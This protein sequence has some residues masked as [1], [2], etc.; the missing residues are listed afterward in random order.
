MKK[1]IMWLREIEQLAHE[2]YVEAAIVYDNDPQFKA[3]L[4]NIAEDKAWHY[5]VMGS[6]AEY[7][8]TTP[9]PGTSSS[10]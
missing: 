9:A 1:L 2:V 7:F 5:H 6:A 3:F 10:G 8:N 4:E